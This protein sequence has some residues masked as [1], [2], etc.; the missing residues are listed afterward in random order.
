[1]P[2]TVI[3]VFIWLWLLAIPLAYNFW[4][5][6]PALY[7]KFLLL[8][9]SL[10]AAALGLAWRGGAAMGSDLRWF[11]APYGIYIALS[12]V[13][14]GMYQ[15][16]LPDGIFAWLQLFALSAM[17]WLLLSMDRYSR[18]SRR[19][20]ALAVTAMAAIASAIAGLQYCLAIAESPTGWHL[21]LADQVTVTFANKN[22]C[23]EVLLLTLPMSLYTAV[24]GGRWRIPGAITLLCTL[25][26]LAITL[27]RAVW[28]AGAVAALVTGAVYLYATGWWRPRWY[29]AAIAV[30]AVVVAFAGFH[31]FVNHTNAGDYIADFYNKRN[32]VRERQHLW[33]ATWHIFTQ[34]IPLGSGM[35]SWRVMNMRYGIVGLRDYTTFFQQPH[36][37]YLWILSDQGLFAFLAVAVAWLYTGYRLLRRIMA[38]PRDLFLYC[39]AFGLA[40]YAVYAGFAFPRERAEH[41][42]L[43]AF[44]VFFI[45]REE[46]TGGATAVPMPRYLYALIAVMLLCGAWYSGQKMWSEI[47]LRRFFAVREI[48]DMGAQRAELDAIDPRYFLLDGTATPVAFYSGML[49]FAQNDLWGAE[50]DFRA[51]VMANPYHAYSLSNVATCRSM[52]GDKPNAERYF[53]EAL[54][55]APGFPDAA[56][57]LCAIKYN[58]HQTDSAAW[59]L[60]MA[61]DTMDDPRYV[62]F[63]KV[64]MGTVLTGMRQ[65]AA[66]KY[67][68]IVTLRL[69]E[70]E[71]KPLWER[72]L[73]RKAYL[74]Q[75]PLRVQIWKDIAYVIRHE[76]GDT[77]AARKFENQNNLH[78]E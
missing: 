78:P 6:D 43:L 11:F 66:G 25:V 58:A 40:G 73:L 64:V 65:E 39:L 62:R 15:T 26:I 27:S 54:V 12:A 60:G 36:N 59:Y 70:I 7:S 56:L 34:Y 16:D 2:R 44:F 19:G 77:A 49:R 10:A 3:S 33:A 68:S 41:G 38:Q 53:R 57:N 67:D 72:N 30:A 1:M 23:A 42:I 69:S 22:I 32:T 13:S 31:W 47:H 50:R 48:R 74:Y 76:D 21:S 9:V 35:G 71:K 45:L 55:Y 20:V 4:T 29:H 46:H 8:D 52:A 75:R 28:V 14:M 61:Q 17:V 37:D 51:A 63:V 24:C 5:L 18:I